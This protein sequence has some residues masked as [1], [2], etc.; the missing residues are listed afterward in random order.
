VCWI[1]FTSEFVDFFFSFLKKLLNSLWS[2]FSLSPKSNAPLL[3]HP[4]FEAIEAIEISEKL[5]QYYKFHIPFVLSLS[6]MTLFVVF[7][8]HI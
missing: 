5:A 6:L 1:L 8:P 4:R 7:I 2:Y 3:C